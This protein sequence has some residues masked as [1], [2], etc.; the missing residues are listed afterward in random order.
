MKKILIIGGSS[1]IGIPIVKLFLN[2][3]YTVF[4]TFNKNSIEAE[5]KKYHLNEFKLDL[6]DKYSIINFSKSLISSKN[7]FDSFIFLPSIIYGLNLNEYK[8][9]NIDNIFLINFISQA[10]LLK[11]ILPCLKKESSILFIS[12]IASKKG[13]Y[14]PFY[15]ATKGAIDSFV[16]SIIHNLPSGIRVN[17]ICPGLIENSSMYTNMSYKIREKHRENTKSKKLLSKNDLAKIIFDLTND[18]YWF[19]L[20]GATIDLNGG[21]YIS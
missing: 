15:A 7:K 1:S 9:E 18:R 12:S 10:K 20:N 11:T 4:S 16:K 3:N 19:H 17:S 14:D 21:E 8:D 13:S 6:T 5:I 2:N